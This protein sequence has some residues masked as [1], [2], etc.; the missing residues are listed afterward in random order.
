MYFYQPV[1]EE[2]KAM[3][4]FENE[5]SKMW[6]KEGILYAVYK[7]NFD[8]TLEIAK[9]CVQA[10][11]EFCKRQTYPMYGDISN[12]KS[13]EK[14]ARQYLSEG[15]GIKYLSAG[16]FLIKTQIEK[17]IGNFW[18]SINK[19]PLPVKLFTDETLAITWLQNYRADRLN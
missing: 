13:T 1:Y 10:R 19:P 11:I 4:L 14:E 3:D 6:I 2:L 8:I 17:Y 5:F 9:E 16:A 18:M 7:P 12:I 15:D